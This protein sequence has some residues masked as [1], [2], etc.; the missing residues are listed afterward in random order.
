MAATPPPT[1]SQPH[2]PPP[3]PPQPRRIVICGGGIIGSCT[4][5]FLSNH[6]NTAAASISITIVEKS[7]IACAASG[8]AGGFLAL[9][10]SDGTSLSS[11]SRASFTLHRTLSQRLDGPTNYSYRPLRTLSL[12]LSLSPSPSLPNPNPSLPSWIDGPVAA[13]KTDRHP[14]HH[15]PAPPEALHP[16]PNPKLPRS[17]CTHWRDQESP[18][19]RRRRR[20]SRR[21]SSS[22]RSRREIRTCGC[23]SARSR[24]LVFPTT[25]RLVTLLRLRPQGPQHRPPSRRPG[26]DN[27]PRAVPHL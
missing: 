26:L 18:S 4:A 3:P 14:R 13:K 16:N 1:T 27:P 25:D 10:W 7:S 21:S 23:R 15:R 11:L 22:C 20:E 9:D 6:N 24:P 5:Y 8:K 2:S 12:S 17:R 19:G